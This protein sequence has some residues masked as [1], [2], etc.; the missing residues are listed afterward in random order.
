MTIECITKDRLLQRPRPD[1][2]FPPAG[3]ITTSPF[4]LHGNPF[5][6]RP[7]SLTNSSIYVRKEKASTLKEVNTNLKS[8]FAADNYDLLPVGTEHIIGPDPQTTLRYENV[9]FMLRF[10]AVHQNVWPSPSPSTKQ[11]EG[12]AQLQVSLFFTSPD[13]VMFHICIPIELTTTAKDENAF[14]KYWLYENPTGNI[15]NGLTFNELFNFKGSAPSVS[16]A[17]SASSASS[18]GK[19]PIVQA[20]F[21]TLNYCLQYNGEKNLHPYIFCLF[22][23]SLRMNTKALPEWITDFTGSGKKLDANRPLTFDSILNFVFRGTINKH[24]YGSIDPYECSTEQHFDGKRTQGAIHPTY[25]SVPVK[26]MIGTVLKEGFESTMLSNVKCYPIDLATQIDDN[27]NV[28]IDTT[29]NKPIDIQS[30]D[31][32]QLKQIDPLLAQDMLLKQ[33]QANDTIVYVVIYTVMSLVLLAI[34]IVAVVYFFPGKMLTG[35]SS[36]PVGPAAPAP[37]APV[38]PAA[39]VAPVAPA[40]PAPT[41]HVAPVATAS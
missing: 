11:T 19:G 33:K 9:T 24:I 3:A 18:S 8:Y 1:I 23:N 37:A 32:N 6:N 16:S 20:N 28:M 35:S 21:A 15:P 25:Y 4:T 13:S 31:K 41:G 12:E 5:T 17:S 34:V 36:V 30:V 14:L 10:V 38:G 39:P 27:G 2:E 22:Q 40:A 26:K 7:Q 29:T